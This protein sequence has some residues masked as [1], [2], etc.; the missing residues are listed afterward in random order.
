MSVQEVTVMPPVVVASD[1]NFAWLNDTIAAKDGNVQKSWNDV[2]SVNFPLVRKTVSSD[3]GK[4][5]K[6]ARNHV[7]RTAFN[8]DRGASSIRRSLED[9][10]VHQEFRGE[11]V[12]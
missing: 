4:N 10:R 1:G 7:A 3:N 5:G 6:P 12:C 2:K 11:S 8:N 9:G